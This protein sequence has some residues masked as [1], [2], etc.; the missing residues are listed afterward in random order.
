MNHA[1]RRRRGCESCLGGG[2]FVGDL[3]PFIASI[4]PPILTSGRQIRPEN[5]AWPTARAVTTSNDSRARS[6]A[7]SSARLIAHAHIAAPT[8]RP[9][10]CRNRLFSWSI[11]SARPA[12]RAGRSPAECRARRRRCRRRPADSSPAEETAEA[13]G[14]RRRDATPAAVRSVMRVRFIVWLAARSRSR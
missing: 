10:G 9:L 5:R 14:R 3:G 12:H 4:F 2:Q 11:R 7:T 1:A 6:R 8:P 13:S